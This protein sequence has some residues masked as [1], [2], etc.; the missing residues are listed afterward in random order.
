MDEKW[1]IESVCKLDFPDQRD[2]DLPRWAEAA[3]RFP[4]PLMVEFG[5]EMSRVLA[6]MKWHLQPAMALTEP[7]LKNAQT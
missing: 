3:A 2:D 7:Q 6:A 4:G 5:A 1:I